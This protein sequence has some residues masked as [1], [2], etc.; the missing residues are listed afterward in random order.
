MTKMSISEIIDKLE[1]TEKEI[2]NSVEFISKYIDKGLINYEIG[3]SIEKNLVNK[4][5]HTYIKLRIQ[6]FN[7]KHDQ[8][9]R[10]EFLSSINDKLKFIKQIKKWLLPKDNDYSS[11]IQEINDVISFYEQKK[12][13]I[14]NEINKINET[15][16]LDTDFSF[17]E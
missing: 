9:K 13:S 7:I 15:H 14:T 16:S 10:Y 12:Q 1:K 4:D 5:M 17:L 8:L 3:R 6:E 2:L 11:L